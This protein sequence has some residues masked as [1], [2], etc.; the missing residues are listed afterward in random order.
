MPQ[1][2]WLGPLIFLLLIDDLQLDCLVH[3]FVD[4]TTLSELLSN[5]DHE[6]HMK[7][8]VKNLRTWSQANKMIINQNKTKEMILGSLAKQ[9]TPCLTIQ[10]G[11]I[12]GQRVDTFKLLGVT[13]SSDLSWEAHVIT[14]CARVAP[15]IYYLKQ[16]NAP[17][18]LRITYCIFT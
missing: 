18:C 4:D 15:R 2:S 6:S 3:K 16:L 11:V 12:E 7:K 10:S 1:G 5:G 13:V 8:Y 9:P 17:G 14:I